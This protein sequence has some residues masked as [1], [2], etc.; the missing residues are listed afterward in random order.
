MPREWWTA[1]PATV[2]LVPFGSAAQSEQTVEI[3]LHPPRTPE[4]RAGTLSFHVGAVCLARS[5]SSG[6]SAAAT[7]MI[8]PYAEHRASL[9]PERSAGRR[10][11]R[12][13]VVVRNRGNDAASFVM[14]A[15]DTDEECHVHFDPPRL[16]LEP[17]AS[18]ASR[19]TVRPP[20]QILIGRP[21]DRQLA[22]EPTTAADVPAL[23]LRAVFR[24]RPW[25]PWWLL[26]L[27]PILIAIAVFLWAFAPRF[28]VPPLKGAR[29]GFDTQRVLQDAGLRL[30]PRERVRVTTK[31]APGTVLDQVP[32]AGKRVRRGTAVTLL[33]AVGPKRHRVPD[34]TGM[35]LAQADRKLGARFKLGAWQPQ[36][37]EPTAPITSQWPAAGQVRHDGTP[38]NVSLT[39]SAPA[40]PGH[41]PTPAPAPKGGGGASSSPPLA[42]D[43]GGNLF[44]AR[45]G[46][47]ATQVSSDGAAT[48]PAWDAQ[49]QMLAYMRYRNGRGRIWAFDPVSD[50]YPGRPLSDGQ[51]DY[52]RPAFAPDG[53]A[54]AFIDKREGRGDLCV[55]PAG[56]ATSDTG[57]RHDAKWRFERL[58]WSPESDAILLVAYARSGSAAGIVEYRSDGTP[59]DAQSWHATSGQD[60]L[61]VVLEDPLHVAW[62]P[63]AD[64]VAVT[65]GQG[66]APAEVAT[67]GVAGGAVESAAQPLGGVT[68]CE[69]A[70]SPDGRLGVSQGACDDA[71]TR[72]IMLVGPGD[73]RTSLGRGADPAWPPAPADAGSGSRP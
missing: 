53:S 69:V 9:K 60:G 22:V 58:A 21:L 5:G 34:V 49:G 3:K 56:G 12:F 70:W 14:A 26:I 68:A 8:E 67:I 73:K 52:H 57:C 30:D 37:A 54:L 39:A 45:D 23:P 50:R 24:Q 32:A 33:L 55:V 7:L 31:V 25:L 64:K 44:V 71:G 62:A 2:H 6:R 18:A 47:D 38:V 17:G 41:V 4:A 61:V 72:E 46:A 1:T 59:A 29:A 28:T 19:L 20:K 15:S 11:G 10:R 48:E 36:S 65:S 27:L 40:V 51:G 42:F 13:T 66:G 63:N 43:D 16:D 35:T